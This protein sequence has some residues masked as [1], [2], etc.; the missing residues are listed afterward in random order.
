MS[1]LTAYWRFRAEEVRNLADEMKDA[2]TKLRMARFAQ[3][4]ERIAKLFENGTLKLQTSSLLHTDQGES[5]QGRGSVQHSGSQA[6]PHRHR[7]AS[8]RRCR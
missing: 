4:Y 8:A 6:A 7:V 5:G 1:L 3:D 2:K